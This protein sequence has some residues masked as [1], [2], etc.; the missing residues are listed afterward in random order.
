MFLTLFVTFSDK[1]LVLEYSE[2]TS[3]RLNRSNVVDNYRSLVVDNKK[4]G[5]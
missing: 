5:K 3:S 4:N 2:G 1:T